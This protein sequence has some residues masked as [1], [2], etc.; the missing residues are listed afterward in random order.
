MAEPRVPN[1]SLPVLILLDPRAKRIKC[2]QLS[3][4][5][6]FCALTQESLGV[7]GIRSVMIPLYQGT[8]D[9]LAKY[10]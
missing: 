10:L 2:E 9:L 1:G 3:G 4:V 6:D 7:I 5:A 8:V